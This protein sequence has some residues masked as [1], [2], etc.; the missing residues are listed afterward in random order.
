MG[1]PTGEGFLIMLLIGVIA[2]AIA[3]VVTKFR[4]GYFADVG[5]GVVAS[6]VGGLLIGKV[7][8]AVLGAGGMLVAVHLWKTGGVIGAIVVIAIAQWAQMV[9]WAT[10]PSV[11][12]Q[13]SDDAATYNKGLPKMVNSDTRLDKVAAGPGK[14]LTYIYT[15]TGGAE[16]HIVWDNVAPSL[17]KVLLERICTSP[18]TAG[19]SRA[20]V[21]ITQRYVDNKGATLAEVSITT[22]DCPGS[23][24]E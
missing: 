22:N 15:Y 19:L 5:I 10:A 16:Q 7:Y 21:D 6:I 14:K 23:R 18:S 17:R 13:L 11:E 20:G 9:Y 12:Q 8:G 3:G 1:A 4:W 24:H 2:G